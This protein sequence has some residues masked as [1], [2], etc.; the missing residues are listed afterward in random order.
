MSGLMRHYLLRSGALAL[1][2]AVVLTLLFLPRGTAALLFAAIGW[3]PM[4]L[5][6]VAGGGWTVSHFGRAGKGFPLAVLTCI[7]LRLLLGLGGLA[8]AHVNAQ[9]MPYL[10]ASL[11]TFAA[12]QLFEMLWFLRRNRPQP[13]GRSADAIG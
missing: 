1:V 3:A 10:A 9:V 7:L 8:V 2:P 11:A 13:A 6:G 4:A 12:M 5:I